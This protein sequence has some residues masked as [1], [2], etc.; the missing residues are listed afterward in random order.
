MDGFFAKGK[1]SKV[2]LDCYEGRKAVRKV[3]NPNFVENLR[4]EA[5]WLVV[6]NKHKI[7]PKL[8]CFG[9]DFIVMEFV[10][11]LRVLDFFAS[12]NKKQIL[13][14]INDVLLQCHK[15]DSLGVNKEELTNPYK[16]VI[17]RKNKPV[18]IDFERCRNTE[19]PKNV[20]QF[21]QFLTSRKVSSLLV[22]KRIKVDVKKFRSAA[23]RYKGSHDLREILSLVRSS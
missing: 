9:K 2:Y 1:R 23:K 11:G 4:N 17:V 21:V 19:T 5:Y 8:F 3:A 15:L 12:A 6:L 13:K 14:V 10:G 20:T 18:M 16:H 22:K 7:G